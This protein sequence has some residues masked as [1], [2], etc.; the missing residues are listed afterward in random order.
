MNATEEN[1]ARAAGRVLDLAYRHKL[2]IEQ[3]PT[4]S[5][6]TIVGRHG[7]PALVVHVTENGPVVRMESASL[8]IEVEGELSLTSDRL[9]V[10]GRESLSL[11]SG[12]DITIGTPGD[13][14]SEAR[15][16]KLTAHLGNVDIKANDDVTMH[17]ERIRMNC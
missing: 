15:T 12:G 3:T 11:T 5:S 16:Q 4:S 2:V 17:G 7:C 10:H 8:K 13:L 9:T 14:S 1:T 6:L